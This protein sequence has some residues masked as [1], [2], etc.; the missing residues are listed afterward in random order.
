MITLNNT[1]DMQAGQGFTLETLQSVFSRILL[2]LI[3]VLSGLSKLAAPAAI[4]GYMQAMGVPTGL[5]YPTIVFEIA[6]GL[7]IILGYQTRVVAY[8]LAAFCL[9]SA[10]IFHHN[11]ADQ[12][13]TV[14][15]LKNLSMAGGFLLLARVGAGSFSLDAWRH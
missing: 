1:S 4:Q 10:A 6:S 8:L 7:L 3:F 13:E 9:V 5:F 14:N 12:N 2:A 11:F 15:F